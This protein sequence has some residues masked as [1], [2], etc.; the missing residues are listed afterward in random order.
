MCSFENF[1][2][3]FNLSIPS[4]HIQFEFNP[5]KTKYVVKAFTYSALVKDDAF[6]ENA[7]LLHSNIVKFTHNENKNKK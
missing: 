5:P 3:I 7:R 2:H 4:D 1:V 6:K